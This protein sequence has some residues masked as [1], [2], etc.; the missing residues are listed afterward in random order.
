MTRTFH[1][2]TALALLACSQPSQAQELPELPELSELPEPL[3][4]FI[5]E[6][7]AGCTE[8][9][10]GTLAVE[11]GAVRRVDLDG[12]R[13]SDWALNESGLASSSSLSFFCGTVGCSSMSTAPPAE[14]ST[15]RPA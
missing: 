8:F 13:R 1:T 9:E 15:R 14:G 7:R 11:W 6:A 5:D 12:D 10:A 3:A 2:L 4:A